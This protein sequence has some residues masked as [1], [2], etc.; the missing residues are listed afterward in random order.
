MISDV[1][2]DANQNIPDDS[3]QRDCESESCSE[4]INVT[5]E[6]ERWIGDGE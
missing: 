5:S 2:H 3:Y 1:P 4:T 6:M